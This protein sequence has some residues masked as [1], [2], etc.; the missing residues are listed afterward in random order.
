MKNIPII[1]K[2]QTGYFRLIEVFAIVTVVAVTSFTTY[3]AI[4]LLKKE[5]DRIAELQKQSLE[6]KNDIKEIKTELKNKKNYTESNQSIVENLT[7][8]QERFLRDPQKGR[9]FVVNELN[10]LAKKNQITLTDGISFA[11]IKKETEEDSSTNAR[12]TR[13]NQK[14]DKASIYPALEAQFSLTSSYANFRRFLYDLESN[15]MFFVIE[16]LTLETPDQEEKVNLSGSPQRVS[17]IQNSTQNNGQLTIQLK[18]KAY[19]HK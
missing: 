16:D 6:L 11:T 12:G 15:K 14:D 1:N 10:D 4:T 8:F 7:S 9:L 3:L 18:V 5:N 19:F 17:T 2:L 13:T